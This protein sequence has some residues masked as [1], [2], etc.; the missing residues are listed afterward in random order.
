ME[1]A[2]QL[3]DADEWRLDVKGPK[4]Y[5]SFNPSIHWDGKQ[6]RCLVRHSDYWIDTSHRYQTFKNQGRIRTKNS[7]LELDNKLRITREV[8][9]V[10]TIPNSYIRFPSDEHGWF[11]GRLFLS[12]DTL[13]IVACSKE[14]NPKLRHEQVLV[15]LGSDYAVTSNLRLNGA[16]SDT[17]QKNWTPF[18][19]E[20]PIQLVQSIDR[21][22]VLH[23]MEGAYTLGGGWEFS[24]L[25]GSSQI[26]KVGERLLGIAHDMTMQRPSGYKVY[27][28]CF[29]EMDWSARKLSQG[30]WFSFGTAPIEY[31]AGLGW[32][33]E[34]LVASFGS[35][36]ATSHVA[37]MNLD[38]V[39][40]NM[41]QTYFGTESA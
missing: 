8:E 19:D 37:V 25:R 23:F 29:Y 12:G 24:G 26:V 6:W 34:R 40:A 14:G 41:S 4:G 35:M 2:K 13:Y 17:T 38:K 21:G 5:T 33:G 15:S 31:C 22:S 28:H 7:I 18:D 16:W 39:L 9:I 36:D 30:P 10:E 1:T 20:L 32:D 27:R 11:D 3:Y